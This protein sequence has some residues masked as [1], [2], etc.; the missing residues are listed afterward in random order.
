MS[1]RVTSEGLSLGRR[2]G[3][4]LTN[5]FLLRVASQR[6]PADGPILIGVVYLQNKCEALLVVAKGDKLLC[7]MVI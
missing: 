7:R 4:I 5:I 1:L 2:N 6:Y 3:L